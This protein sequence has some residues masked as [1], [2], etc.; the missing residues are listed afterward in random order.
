MVILLQD[1][2]ACAPEEIKQLANDTLS[3]IKNTASE[4]FFKGEGRTMVKDL[5]TLSGLLAEAK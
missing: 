5:D 3:E 2:H 1:I 4:Y